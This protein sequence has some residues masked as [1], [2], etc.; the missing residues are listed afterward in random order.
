MVVKESWDYL[1]CLYK[2]T[3]LKSFSNKKFIEFARELMELENT[4]LIK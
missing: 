2:F 4:E 3:N 1:G